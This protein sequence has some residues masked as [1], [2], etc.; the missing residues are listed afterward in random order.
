MWFVKYLGVPFVE[1]GRDR[2]GWDCWGLVRA[3]YAEELGIVLP[4]W[5]AH[6]GS[7]DNEAIALEVQEAHQHFT[8]VDLP[9]PM[10]IVWFST[11]SI[12]AHVGI[13]V[14]HQRMLHCTAGKDTCVESWLTRTG[15]LKGFYVP[16][17]NYRSPQP[18]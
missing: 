1:L 4:E 14:D 8:R 15:Q 5:S 12:Y 3:V 2:N 11:R 6:T 9:E 13:V 16:N 18:V 17:Q 7:L 10:S